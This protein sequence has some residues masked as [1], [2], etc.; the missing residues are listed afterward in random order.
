MKR[1]AVLLIFSVGSVPAMAQSVSDTALQWSIQA[2]ALQKTC[3]Y[4]LNLKAKREFRDAMVEKFG[5]SWESAGTLLGAQAVLDH[6]KL[7]RSKQAE[8]CKAAKAIA[9][10]LG[11]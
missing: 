11:G 5:N 2:F 9:D 10:L 3:G 1:I 6:E 4:S 7:S 8:V